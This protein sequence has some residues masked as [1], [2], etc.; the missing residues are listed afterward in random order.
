MSK[1]SHQEDRQAV[2]DAHNV[3]HSR[4]SHP[5]DLIHCVSARPQTMSMYATEVQ[6]RSRKFSVIDKTLGPRCA[7]TQNNL[8]RQLQPHNLLTA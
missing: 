8:T 3:E 5:L 6:M 2:P 7:V 1:P 4:D